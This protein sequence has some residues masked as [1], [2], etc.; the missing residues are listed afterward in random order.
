MFCLNRLCCL[1]LGTLASHLQ[2]SLISLAQLH[3]RLVVVVQAIMTAT[4][5]EIPEKTRTTTSLSK[6]QGAVLKAKS[7]ATLRRKALH[8]MAGS[9]SIPVD[10]L[11]LFILGISSIWRRFLFS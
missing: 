7:K 3:L 2:E 11:M 9:V 1:E 4:E 10:L 6:S 5:I 8:A